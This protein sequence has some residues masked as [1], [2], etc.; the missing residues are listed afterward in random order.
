MNAEAMNDEL[1]LACD[2][3]DLVA[4]EQ[5]LKRGADV[6]HKD[7]QG[8]TALMVATQKNQVSLAKS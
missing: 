8:R 5:L 4:V 3:G 7:S 2:R 6:H 1:I